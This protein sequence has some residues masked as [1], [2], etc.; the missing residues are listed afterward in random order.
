MATISEFLKNNN[1]YLN[2]LNINPRESVKQN[3][4]FFF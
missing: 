3:N 2:R 1:K 4:A